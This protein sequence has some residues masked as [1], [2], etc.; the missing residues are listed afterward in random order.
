MKEVR[1]RKLRRSKYQFPTRMIRQGASKGKLQRG[2]ILAKTDI[3]RACC[4]SIEFLPKAH[5]RYE[6][7]WKY[8]V[9]MS[10]EEA[11]EHYKERESS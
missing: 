1:Y 2:S 7:R 8:P 4:C 6:W 5:T 10:V 11:N 9:E 3:E